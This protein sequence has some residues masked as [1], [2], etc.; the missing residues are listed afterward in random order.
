[1]T[2]KRERESVYAA[3]AMLGAAAALAGIFLFTANVSAKATCLAKHSVDVC[4]YTLR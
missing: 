3:L 2:P 1:M 4:E